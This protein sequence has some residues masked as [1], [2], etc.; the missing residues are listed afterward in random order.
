MKQGLRLK[1]LALPEQ[2]LDAALRNPC[3]LGDAAERQTFDALYARDPNGLVENG[4]A[5]L[6]TPRAALDMGLRGIAHESEYIRTNVRFNL[7]ANRDN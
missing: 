2:D 7:T 3:S 6:V 1:R 4:A 5:A